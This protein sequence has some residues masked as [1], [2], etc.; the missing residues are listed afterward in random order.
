MRLILL[1]AGAALGSPAQWVSYP[2]PGIPRTSDGKPNLTAP[3]PRA[4]DGRPDLSGLWQVE[5]TPWAEMKPLVGNLNDV[6]A[7]GDDLREFSKYAINILADFR[8][9]DAPLWSEAAAALRQPR[10]AANACLPQ[11]LPFVYLIPTP[12]NWIQTPRLIAIAVEGPANVRQIYTDGA[13][14]S[15]RRAAHVAGVLSGSLGR[16]HARG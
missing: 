6:F 14:I 12:A 7:P 3:A 16:R 11:G 1:F 4:S 13:Q 2:T 15:S 10:A 5:P 9:E 8:P